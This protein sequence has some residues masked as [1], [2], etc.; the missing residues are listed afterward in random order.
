[1]CVI[2]VCVCL[3]PSSYFSLRF[4][5][6]RDKRLQQMEPPMNTRRVSTF[7]MLNNLIH[8]PF[9]KKR[10]APAP[11]T[12]L[13]GSRPVTGAAPASKKLRGAANEAFNVESDDAIVTEV[14]RHSDGI[15]ETTSF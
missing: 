7:Q 10:T 12:P 1:M 9:D 3:H 14:M 4:A 13:P 8:A 11:V 5:H 15:S 6:P 2:L